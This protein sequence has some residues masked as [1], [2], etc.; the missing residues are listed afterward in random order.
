VSIAV[1]I[2]IAT[3]SKKVPPPGEFESWVRAALKGKR[4]NAEITVRIVGNRE[5]R[6][7]NSTWRNLDKPTNVL[8][9]PLSGLERRTGVLNGDIVVCAPLVAREA[10]EQGKTG[11]AHWAHLVVHGTLHLIGYDH[12]NDADAKTMEA[13]E[14]RVL[15]NLG[16]GNPY[17]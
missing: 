10:R 9:F 5:S 7:L 2:Q 13:V 6:S 3:R 8:S 16:F 17:A 15:R 14:V 11:K 4:K 1:H 12:D